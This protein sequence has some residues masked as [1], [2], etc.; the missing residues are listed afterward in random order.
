M[1]KRIDSYFDKFL[2]YHTL[3]LSFY[4]CLLTRSQDLLSADSGSGV[5]CPSTVSSFIFFTS[6]SISINVTCCDGLAFK[7]SQQCS[8]SQHEGHC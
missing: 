7:F 3:Y 8:R 5:S 4:A 2:Y 1:I 6:Q